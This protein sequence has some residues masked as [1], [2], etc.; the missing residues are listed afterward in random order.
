MQM[1]QN[2]E[3]FPGP[4]AAAFSP[5]AA[6]I[7]TGVHSKARAYPAPSYSNAAIQFLPRRPP[8]ASICTM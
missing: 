3:V 6:A 8:S 4:I 5:P 2:F 1:G 7:M